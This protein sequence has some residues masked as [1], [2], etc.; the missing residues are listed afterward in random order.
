M[1]WKD[2]YEAQMDLWRLARS[3]A[4]PGLMIAS[5]GEENR[6]GMRPDT[7]EMLFDMMK[8]E[9]GKLLT[10]DP[11][12]VAEEF[13]D[14]VDEARWSFKPEPLH[15]Q[16]FLTPF[17]FVY[18]E[19]PI[20]VY[21][22]YETPTLLAGFS[23]CPTGMKGVENVEQWKAKNEGLETTPL[24]GTD[25]E[26]T[27][28]ALTLYA[29][30]REEGLWRKLQSKLSFLHFTPWWFGMEFSGNDVDEQGRQTMASEWWRVVQVSLRLMQET[31]SERSEAQA[32]RASRRRGERAGFD[33]RTIVVIRLR[34]PKQKAVEPGGEVN[35]SHRWI[36]QGFWRR[37]W[38][39][40]LG[41]HRQKWIGAYVKG[42]EGLPL[43]TK[44]R[45]WNWDK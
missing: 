4:G 32:D 44:R 7:V 1:N 37:Q 9:E 35:W 21:A 5:I 38:Y 40:S 45:A 41:I 33:P 27:G 30:V 28:I 6:R 43:I 42:P 8:A 20:E 13:C 11:F 12:F 23:W 10:A 14:L 29:G 16:D 15:P 31:I 17:G 34:R 2:A 22:Q 25:I 36:V 39:P 18:F 3:E 26:W 24:G 19:K